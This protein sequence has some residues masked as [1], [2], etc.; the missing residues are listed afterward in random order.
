M[1]TFYVSKGK[2]KYVKILV[3]YIRFGILLGGVVFILM[4]NVIY[5]F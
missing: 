1:A 5:W 4:K 2:N 3:L